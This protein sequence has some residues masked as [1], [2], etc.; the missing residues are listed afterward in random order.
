MSF[1]KYC[2][3]QIYWSD[4]KGK[5][6]PFDDSSGSQAHKCDNFKKIKTS[7]EQKIL[8]LEEKVLTSHNLIVKL[9]SKIEDLE[10]RIT[11]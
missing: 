1:C 2:S 3:N 8:E 10:R 4:V 11:A 7:Q 5:P 9:F 6:K